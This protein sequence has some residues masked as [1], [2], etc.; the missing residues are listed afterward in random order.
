MLY[1]FARVPS[2]QSQYSK[3]KHSVSLTHRLTF[4][5]VENLQSV[6]PTPNQPIGQAEG[7]ENR[8]R[9]AR[10]VRRARSWECNENPGAE[11]RREKFRGRVWE[12]NS[13]SADSRRKRRFA[14]CE[15]GRERT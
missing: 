14:A 15:R 11:T 5:L 6:N 3:V 7:T 4:H 10:I 1:P 8:N 13:P 12:L 9:A 2:T